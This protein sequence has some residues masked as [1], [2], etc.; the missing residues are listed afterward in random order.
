MAMDNGDYFALQE[1]D[2]QR[3]I[4][5]TRAKFSVFSRNH[6]GAKVKAMSPSRT[7]LIPMMT[8]WC[9]VMGL[10]YLLLMTRA[11]PISWAR[12]LRPQQ[13]RRRPHQS[14]PATA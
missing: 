2:K 12:S 11:W 5:A 1:R 9:V 13:Q 6:L 14:P 7:G 4:D 3:Q 10:L 8:F